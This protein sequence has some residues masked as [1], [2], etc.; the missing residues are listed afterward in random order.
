MTNTQKIEQL[1]FDVYDKLGKPVNVNVVRAML[2]SMSIRAV[3]AKQEYGID[4][5]QE[6]AKMVFAQITNPQFLE[7]NPSSLPVNEQLL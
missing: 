4:D 3:D 6:L 5:L 2:E 1:G 7:E